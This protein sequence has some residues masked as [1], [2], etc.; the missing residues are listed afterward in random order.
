MA[1]FNRGIYEGERDE[2][3]KRLRRGFKQGRWQLK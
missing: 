2:I 3:V 1:I